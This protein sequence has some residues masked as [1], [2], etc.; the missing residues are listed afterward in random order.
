MRRPYVAV[1]STMTIDGRIA[2]RTGFSKLSCPYDLKRLHS[3]RASSDAIIVGANTVIVDDPLLTVRYVKGRNPVRVIID[4]SL[5][6][7]PSARV[8]NTL[9]EA[10]TIVYTSKKS[11]KKKK[12]ILRRKGVEVVELS[13][14]VLLDVL[15]ILEDLYMRGV[16]RV[17]VEGGGRTIWSFI[18]R[19]VVD[20]LMI[21]IAPYVFG[22]GVSVVE[23]GGFNDITD[24]LSFK[25]A[26][27]R[28][29]ECGK[30]LHV[31]YIR[32]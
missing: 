32:E 24:A 16:R 11:D 25:L 20:E 7:N 18:S 31:R 17:L 21:T 12:E 1:Y 27:L 5:R 10:K 15:S 9:N 19:R 28:I 13:D 22:N 4:G 6:T 8:Y 26:E 30:E 14:D 2:S 3:V 29:C 23:G